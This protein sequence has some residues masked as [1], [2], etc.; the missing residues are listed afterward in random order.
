MYVVSEKLHTKLIIIWI[1]QIFTKNLQRISNNWAKQAKTM[2][3]I[4]YPFRAD[5][6]YAMPMHHAW[7]G[8]LCIVHYI[9]NMFRS[10]FYWLMDSVCG[11]C[12]GTNDV[13]PE[14]SNHLTTNW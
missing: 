4:S 9:T 13:Q 7:Y 8:I 6:E 3:P 2:L 11:L 12:V 5:E 14:N 1:N 10:Q